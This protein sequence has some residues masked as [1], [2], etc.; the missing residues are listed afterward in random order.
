ME[1]G[2]VRFCALMPARPLFQGVFQWRVVIDTSPTGQSFKTGQDGIG[3]RRMQV[4]AGRVHPQIPARSGN[5]LSRRKTQRQLE[6]QADPFERE[7]LR[8]YCRGTEQ[9]SRRRRVVRACQR[10]SER[11]C[12]VEAAEWVWLIRP[13][14]AARSVGVTLGMMLSPI[15]IGDDVNDCILR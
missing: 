6:V 12:A 3:L 13:V 1:S 8:R 5:L 4:A 11:W 10:Q 2:R 15:M 14:K 9:S 7:R